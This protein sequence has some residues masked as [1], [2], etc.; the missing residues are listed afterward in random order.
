MVDP[1]NDFLSESGLLYDR[2]RETLE[3]NNAIEHMED[4]ITAARAVDIKI[5]YVS[6][7]QSQEGDKTDWKFG[8]GA[9]GLFKAG[10][11]GVEYYPHL[12]M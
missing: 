11:W 6:H 5:I 12:R 4:L 9:S 7:H 10:T 8:R 1:Y 3:A 2:V